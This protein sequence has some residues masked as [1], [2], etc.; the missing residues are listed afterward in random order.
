MTTQAQRT[1]GTIE[2]A[3]AQ[4]RELL[5]ERLELLTARKGCA[6]FLEHEAPTSAQL[7]Q[8]RAVIRKIED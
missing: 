5:R 1:P 3:E 8:V 7:R 6:A 2:V 4:Y